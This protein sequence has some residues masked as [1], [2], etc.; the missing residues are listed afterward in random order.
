MGKVFINET[1]LTAIGD[2][3]RE[4][5]GG[6]ELLSPAEMATAIAGIETGG[7][8]G[9]DGVPETVSF[10]G[11]QLSA[12]FKDN[13]WQWF[14]ENYS[15]RIKT[16]AITY[17]DKLFEGCSNYL[18]KVDF[19]INTSTSGCNFNSAF[20]NCWQLE[21][22]PPLENVS[23]VSDMFYGCRKLR[24][25]PSITCKSGG[26]SGYEVFS[27]CYSLRS[28][29]EEFLKGLYNA[30]ATYVSGCTI[31]NMFNG[32]YALDEVRGL[33]PR[34]SAIKGNVFNSIGGTSNF[35]RLKEF[36]FATQDDGTPYVV[37]LSGQVLDL[38]SV[39][40]LKTYDSALT[41]DYNSGITTDKKVTNA[42]EYAALKNDPDYYT[43]DKKFSRYTLQ[44]AINTI[45]SLPD[46]TEYLATTSGTNTIKFNYYEGQE[47]D[48]GMIGNMT[49]EQIAVATA[50][51]WTVSIVQ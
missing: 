46:T 51:G 9:S 25:L 42:A 47:T 28:I 50:K 30:S 36:I 38:S 13:K 35:Q 17:A 29:P 26:V 5:T 7:G 27:G 2:A 39:G 3:I 24:E 8:D 12:L 33:N 44:S 18:K 20:Y 40:V 49:E 37:K 32:C 14:I 34:V 45:N 31:Y 48:G 21:S 43:G 22:I 23:A 4:K 11:S 10:T 19:E 1:S 6:T 15:D 41:T 16:S